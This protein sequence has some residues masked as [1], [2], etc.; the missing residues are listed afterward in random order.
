MYV[1]CKNVY[2][3]KLCRE[4]RWISEKMAFGLP[5]DVRMD[6]DVVLEK[7]ALRAYL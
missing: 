5:T 7:I 6:T 4:I 3:R 2:L 1:L